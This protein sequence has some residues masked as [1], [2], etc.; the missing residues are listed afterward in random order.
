MFGA[1]AA[2][3]AV[4]VA[5][6]V[7]AVVAYVASAECASVPAAD[8]SLRWRSASCIADAAYLVAAG[9]SAAVDLASSTDLPAA[10]DTSDLPLY[11]PY[12]E[13][14]DVD[15]RA[16]LLDARDYSCAL[17][18]LGWFHPSAPLRAR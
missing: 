5:A 3:F 7:H 16:D 8:F 18:Q 13:L 9:V 10:S 15:T 6:A 11:S 2:A 17:S 14:P 12:S 4:S 1:L